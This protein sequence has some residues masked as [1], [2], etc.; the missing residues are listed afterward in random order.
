MQKLEA[1]QANMEGECE[2][3]EKLVKLWKAK[4]NDLE[5]EVNALGYLRIYCEKLK[6]YL[7]GLEG[8]KHKCA[9]LQQKVTQIE[10]NV[11]LQCFR[12]VDREINSGTLVKKGWYSS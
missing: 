6:K 8:R 10:S 7:A 1:Q 12:A 11:E 9:E 2:Q 5:K 4:C 3:L